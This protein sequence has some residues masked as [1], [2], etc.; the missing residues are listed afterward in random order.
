[1]DYQ[2]P[3]I[4]EIYDVAN[5]LGADGEFYLSVAGE[6]PCSVLDL[7]CGTG[8]LSCALAER[9][10]RVTG[11]DPAAAMLNVAK[12]KPSADRVEWVASSAQGY[13]SQRR[14]D[15]IVMTGHAFQCLLT[16]ADARA[17]LTTMRLHLN[18]GGRVAFETRNPH[19]DWAG[20]WAA[21]APVFHSLRGEEVVETLEVTGKD[22]EFISFV[23]SYRFPKRTLS[24][25]S[26]LR[27]P[28]R[29]HVEELMG[30]A[31]LVVSEVFGDW[32]GSPFV[33]EES[34]EMIFCSGGRETLESKDPLKQRKL[35]WGT[36]LEGKDR[37]KIV[38]VAQ[39]SL[40]QKLQ[41]T[42]ERL[43][44]LLS[45]MGCLISVAGPIVALVLYPRGKWLFA[46]AGLGIAVIVI[47]ILLAKDATPDEIADLAERLLDG[48][49][50]G[51][52]VDDYEHL[53]PREP[54][55]RELWARTMKSAAG[56]R[57]GQEY[58]RLRKAN[59]EKRSPK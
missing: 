58:L 59:C 48:T 5:P 26:T 11:V 35:E 24:T 15:L 25:S 19:V 43:P 4:A 3:E 10:H 41:A 28:S 2:D 57:L 34:R 27:F 31:G 51:Y 44:K 50:A 21:R 37:H 6:R 13:R 46:L 17:A 33:D 7:G 14:F 9:G 54:Q 20:E 36:T 45:K 8:T 18:T 29:E 56:L 55:L 1:M 16:D 22:T 39:R 12:R 38:L 30:R 49:P 40:L 42:M 47:D 32:G 52:D 53:N 23:T